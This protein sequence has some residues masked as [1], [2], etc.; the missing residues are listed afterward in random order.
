M[1]VLTLLSFSFQPCQF[2]PLRVS[3]GPVPVRERDVPQQR[4][5][6]F[7]KNSILFVGEKVCNILCGKPFLLQVLRRLRR[8]QG[9]D[10]R[11]A[12]VQEELQDHDAVPLPEKGAKSIPNESFA[13]IKNRT[14][15]FFSDVRRQH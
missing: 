8:L 1:K 5:V 9:R 12:G 11:A 13:K 6:S 15:Y 4:K 10:R 7:S 14:L 2:Y 3:L